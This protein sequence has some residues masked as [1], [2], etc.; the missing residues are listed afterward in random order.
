MRSGLLRL[1]RQEKRSGDF[2]E[3]EGEEENSYKERKE[4]NMDARG[5]S[6]LKMS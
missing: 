6:S 5:V 3:K 4:A 2:S 1:V